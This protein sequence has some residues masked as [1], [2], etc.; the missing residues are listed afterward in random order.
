MPTSR[1]RYGPLFYVTLALALIGV[2]AVPFLPKIHEQW[3]AWELSRQLGDSDSHVR[4]EAARRLADL[5]PGATWWIIWK[6]RHE[7][8]RVRQLACSALVRNAPENTTRAVAALIAASHDADRFVRK[9]AVDELHEFVISASLA[10]DAGLRVEDDF[11]ISLRAIAALRKI[12]PSKAEA[13]E[14]G[15]RAG[16][17]RSEQD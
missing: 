12:D 6:M 7:D 3:T 1:R 5:G 10:T 8:P 14:R 4:G 15:I 16:T 13:V 2:A 9:A 17:I 11:L